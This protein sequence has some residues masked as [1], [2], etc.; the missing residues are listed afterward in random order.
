MSDEIL[1]REERLTQF[2]RD[3]NTCLKFSRIGC[4]LVKKNHNWIIQDLHR[5]EEYL[6]LDFLDLAKGE[7][8]ET[9]NPV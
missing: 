3:I 6:L 4:N 8:D 1:T 7:T 5:N 2:R 9:S